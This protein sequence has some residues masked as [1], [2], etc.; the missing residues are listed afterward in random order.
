MHNKCDDCGRLFVTKKKLENHIDEVHFGLIERCDFCDKEF[1]RL[2]I[3]MRR[4]HPIEYAKKK[5]EDT[6]EKDQLEKL[7]SEERKQRNKEWRESRPGRPDHRLSVWTGPVS[8]VR[9]FLERNSVQSY[10][11]IT[12]TASSLQSFIIDDEWKQ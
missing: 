7:R 1:R 5:S 8:Q 2:A 6:E 11:T 12:D 4:S 9:G 3:H 10:K